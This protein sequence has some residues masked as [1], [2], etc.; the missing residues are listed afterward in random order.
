MTESRK[1]IKFK[2]RQLP[3]AI[4]QCR[5]FSELSVAEKSS[6]EYRLNYIEE[7]SYK[8]DE[9]KIETQNDLLSFLNRIELDLY[10]NLGSPADGISSEISAW[11]IHTSWIDEYNISAIVASEL[12]NYSDLAEP[13][14]TWTIFDFH[15]WFGKKNIILKK[16]IDLF[17]ESK[18]IE[19]GLAFIYIVDLTIITLLFGTMMLRI[20]VRNI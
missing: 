19:A 4:A 12:A 20:G 10:V 11:I 9:W 6:F 8:I 3:K 16:S 14:L 17:Y 5:W 2:R 18:T 15:V 7:I 1:I 13:K